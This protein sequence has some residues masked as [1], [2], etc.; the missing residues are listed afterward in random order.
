MLPKLRGSENYLTWSIRVKAT[1]IKED[2]L[3]PIEETST[4]TKNY[5]ALALIQLFCEDGPLLYI[6]DIVSA[7]EA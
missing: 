4:G 7:K 2:L 3:L 5:K 1:L 6:K